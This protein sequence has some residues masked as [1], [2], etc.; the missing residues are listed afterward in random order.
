MDL[1]FDTDPGFDGWMAWALIEA[2]PSM[3]LHGVS[4]VAGNAPLNIS[5][6][7]ALA[8]KA[9]HGFA[10][11]V[12]AGCDRPLAMA[13][14]TAQDVLGDMGMETTGPTLPGSAAPPTP[15]HGV[16]ALIDCVRAHPGRITLLAV[17]PLT[18]VA[19]AFAL[20][21]ELPALLAGLVIMGG[22]TIGGNITAAAEFNIHADPEAAARVFDCGVPV[23]M[24]GLNV[25]RQLPIGQ[26]QIDRLKAIGSARAALFAGYLEG[27]VA[28]GRRRGRPVQ[29]LYDPTP[30]IW[31][32]RPKLF[33]LQAARVDIELQGRFT[34]GMTVC[35][36]RTPALARANARVA[37]K[38]DGHAALEWA[39]QRLES[40]LAA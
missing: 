33:D 25:C 7:N 5:L 20:A 36:L 3:R 13:P 6:A 10:A 4:V 22:S 30:V 9:L 18:N 15:G 23:Q 37:V 38:A 27:Y 17:G 2:E 26:P 11:P 32:A 21:P 19:T 39:M 8:I 14:V 40:L 24:F 1:W 34:R 35:D 28:I 31:L 12:H 29:S 16:Q